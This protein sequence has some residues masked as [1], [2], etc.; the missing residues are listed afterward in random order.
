M[1]LSGLGAMRLVSIVGHRCN[2]KGKE[3]AWSFAGM[4][5]VSTVGLR[6]IMSR[7]GQ[8]RIYT[9]YMTVYLVISLPKIPYIHR[10]YM[11]LA[12]PNHKG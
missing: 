1:C 4:W 6:C 3:M 11:V 12:N 5:L 8:D 10:I 7:V 2:I 9:P